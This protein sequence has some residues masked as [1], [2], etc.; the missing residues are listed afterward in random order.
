MPSTWASH[1]PSLCELWRTGC[2]S[3]ME[4]TRFRIRLEPFVFDVVRLRFLAQITFWVALLFTFVEAEMPP[5]HALPLFPWD[6]AEHFTAFYV[7]TYLAVAAFPSCSLVVVAIA[8]SGFGALIELV[9]ALPI[10]GRDCDFWDW[11]ADSVGIG[12][13]L[14]PMLLVWWRNQIQPSA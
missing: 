4:S 6:K 14:A 1:P 12:A 13:A 8:L 11:V 2:S 7:L 10:V 9:Q 3:R 5:Q